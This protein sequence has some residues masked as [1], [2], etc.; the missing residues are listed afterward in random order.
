MPKSKRTAPMTTDEIPKHRRTQSPADAYFRAVFSYV[1]VAEQLIRFQMPREQLEQLDLSTLALAS[2]SFVDARLRKSLSD[3]VYTC[4]LKNGGTAR[5]CL[6]IEHKSQRPGRLIYPQINRYICGIQEEDVKQKRKDFTLT[7]PILFYHGAEAWSHQPLLQLY[8]PLPVGMERFVPAFDFVVVDVQKMSREAIL[9]MH[10]TMAL[11]NIFLVLKKQWDDNFFK[12][13]FSDIVIFVDENMSQELCDSL[14]ELTWQFIQ[15]I[16]TLT[17]KDIMEVVTA[18][19]PKYGKRVKST[20]QQMMESAAKK[21]KAMVEA[22]AKAVGRQEG[23]QEGWQEGRQKG[24]QEGRQEG[25]LI[26]TDLGLNIA[27]KKAMLNQPAFTDLQIAEL[28]DVSLERVQN[29]RA[30]LKNEQS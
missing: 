30:E 1:Q 10:H 4:G 8:G 25:V 26:G 27:I 14:F 9:T 23:R 11:R 18:L 21:A 28:L 20:Y 24:R 15:H 7:I 22:E 5:I 2:D 3:L 29:I 13:H 19:P 16:S 6:L 17:E 12:G